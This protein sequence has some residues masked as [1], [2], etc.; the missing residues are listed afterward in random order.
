MTA[1]APEKRLRPRKTPRQ[2]RAVETRARILDAAR[3]VF[4]EHGYAAGTTNRIA[5]QAEMSVGSLYQYFPNKD[6]ILVELVQEHIDHGTHEVLAA[7]AATPDADGDLTSMV[8]AIVAA[9][10]AVHARDRR[11]HQVLFEESPR[12]PSLLR[13]L[14]ELEDIVVASIAARLEQEIP[15]VVDAELVA[16]ITVVTIESLVH[17]LVASDRP[18]DTDAFTTEVTALV[19]GYL[20]WHASHDASKAAFPSQSLLK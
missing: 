16:R 5:E 7:L 18:L 6:A 20:S 19:V 17:R 14:H 1:P 4:A 15:G 3:D 11:L 10:V 12:P 8:P 9:L 2:P 13:R